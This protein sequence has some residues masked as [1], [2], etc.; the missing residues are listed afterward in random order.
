M[1]EFLS[2]VG[3]RWPTNMDTYRR[4]MKQR[5]GAHALD[6]IFS[7]FDKHGRPEP[8]FYESKNRNLRFSLDLSFQLD[9]H[10]LAEFMSGI[11]IEHR[12]YRDPPKKALDLGCDCG[13]LACF[14]AWHFPEAEVLGLDITENAIANA[15]VLAEKLE[16]KNVSFRVANLSMLLEM[17][18]P[19]GAFD[20]VTC[21]SVLHSIQEMPNPGVGPLEFLTLPPADAWSRPL[22]QI[23][24]LLSSD[25]IFVSSERLAT[26]RALGWCVRAMAESGMAVVWRASGL[27]TYKAPDEQRHGNLSSRN[28]PVLTGTRGEMKLDSLPPESERLMGKWK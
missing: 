23:A 20:L 1:L 9:G 27:L 16:L 19:Q 18:L 22:S 14:Y 21:V 3:V 10:F 4:Q 8:A 28:K 13:I 17:Q 25:G 6:G 26:K 2:K 11:V 12:K 15:S 24:P 7:E 5:Y